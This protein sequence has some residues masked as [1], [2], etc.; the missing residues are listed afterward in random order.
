MHLPRAKLQGRRKQILPL[1]R[2]RSKDDK[3]MSENNNTRQ[4]LER[5]EQP[6][7]Y[8]VEAPRLVWP[9]MGTAAPGAPTRARGP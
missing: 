7:P 9:V 5:M 1:L 8:M 6:R 2:R 3:M 4:Q